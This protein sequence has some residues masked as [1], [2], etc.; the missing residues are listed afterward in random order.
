MPKVGRLTELG[1]YM[2]AFGWLG[3]A[4]ASPNQIAPDA[5]PAGQC[6]KP[7]AGFR[8]D[9]FPTPRSRPETNRGYR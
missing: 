5:C 4:G 3:E 8:R 2:F 9:P 7:P 6:I 1:R